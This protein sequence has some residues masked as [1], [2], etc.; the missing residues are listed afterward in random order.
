MT[1]TPALLVDQARQEINEITIEQWQNNADNYLLVDVRE[2]NELAQG[3]IP[4][5]SHIPRGLLEFQ[6]LN[7]PKLTNLPDLDKASANILLYC[8][9]GGRSALAAKSLKNMGFN[10][11]SSLA[12]GYSEWLKLTAN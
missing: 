12:G 10:N 4:N 8:Q 7:H 11:V 5:A 9:S 3:Q 6:I 1:M 2:A